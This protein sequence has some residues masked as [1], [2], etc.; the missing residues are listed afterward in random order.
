MIFGKKKQSSH[1]FLGRETISKQ[2]SYNYVSAKIN[3]FF[4]L[5]VLDDG[6]PAK[7]RVRIS[8]T[9]EGDTSKNQGAI[10][11]QTFFYIYFE[12]FRKAKEIFQRVSKG[13]RC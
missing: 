11:I 1:T 9:E 6:P 10:S 3:I 7:F 5:V 2:D 12:N 8:N 13:G 4:L